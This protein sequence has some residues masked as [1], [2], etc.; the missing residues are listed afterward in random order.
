MANAVAVSDTTFGEI[1]ERHEGLV[2]VDFGADW[3]GPCR[4]IAPVVEQLA[5]E[6][7]GRA[8]IA[9]LDVDA[10]PKTAMRFGV[11]SLPTLLFF[12]D[13]TVIDTVVGAV[14]KAVLER[15]LQQHER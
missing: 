11:R 8:R 9:K 7:E 12:K 2:L 10:N 1:V 13:G 15:K 14:P 4:A 5:V 3:C 6:Y